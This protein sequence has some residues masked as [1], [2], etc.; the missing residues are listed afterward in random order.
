MKY[1]PTLDHAEKVARSVEQMRL[2]AS[3]SMRFYG[4]PLLVCYSGG[5][6]SDVLLGLAEMSGI[7]YE[8]Q[9]SKTT[10]DA[11]ETVR[12]VRRAFERLMAAG[13]RCETTFP[14]YKGQPVTM[15][16][17]IPQKKMPPTRFVRYCC[18]ILKETGGKKRAIATGVR[19]SESSARKGRMFA[20]NFS[21]ARPASLDFE[22]AASLFED[23]DKAIEHDNDFM[24]SCRIRGKTS[25]QPILEWSDDDVW[26][27]ID[28]RGIET[29]P[30]YDEGFRRVGCIGCPLAS[31]SE[32]RLEF[33]RWPRYKE[34]Y[35]RA[36]GKL[37][38]HRREAGLE[39]E[40]ETAEEVFEWWMSR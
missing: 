6:D 18:S 25:F 40:W 26:Q 36:F 17:L 39:T 35:I 27:F 14:T 1:Q 38:D 32:R 30:L 21:R 28:E 2:A 3:M 8:V 5:K 33:E 7:E 4:K 22:D 13:V 37:L 15:W 12:H 31:P 20:N 24:R 9:H 29:N 10:A 11:P 23:A 34:A 16:S 19:R